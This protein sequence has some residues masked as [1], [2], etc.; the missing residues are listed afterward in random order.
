MCIG[1]L[2]GALA[3]AGN[4]ESPT[5]LKVRMYVQLWTKVAN[6]TGTMSTLPDGHELLTTQF[7][8]S[9]EW[10]LFA[11]ADVVESAT[12]ADVNLMMS[13]RNGRVRLCSRQSRSLQ[14]V[15]LTNFT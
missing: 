7:P 11:G 8:Q 6:I 4:P 13:H 1:P 9:L 10:G 15:P 14:N 2:E 12:Q 3:E 5:A